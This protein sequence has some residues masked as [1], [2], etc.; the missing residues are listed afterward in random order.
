[1]KK[2]L[3]TLLI[4]IIALAGV[5]SAST[6][7]SPSPIEVN[8]ISNAETVI[9]V[10]HVDNLGFATQCTFEIRDDA[11]TTLNDELIGTIDGV[12]W[13][14]ALSAAPSNTYM[15]GS[16]YVSEWIFNVKDNGDSND[17]TQVGTEYDIHFV[18]D[19]NNVEKETVVLAR[20][21][22]TSDVTAIPEFPTVAL[23]V[24]A[25]LG[26]AFFMQRRKEE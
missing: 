11:S 10:T 13:G 1:M 22:S 21:S 24:A 3:T 9:T 14:N 19:V 4:A 8:I 26:L 18:V 25:I 12:T 2:I 6:T 23:P 16:N 17:N 5:A 20:G 7:F 15:D